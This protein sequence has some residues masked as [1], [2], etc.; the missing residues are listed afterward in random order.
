MR[1]VAEREWVRASVAHRHVHILGVVLG[2]RC[3]YI[4]GR[5]WL[6]RLHDPSRSA[7]SSEPEV[8][9]LCAL[10]CVPVCARSCARAYRS[11]CLNT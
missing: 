1:Q 8:V 9:C 10:V 6:L 3:A 4:W 5:R 7:Q 11:L 2:D